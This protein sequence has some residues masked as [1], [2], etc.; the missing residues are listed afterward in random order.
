MTISEVANLLNI[1]Q[2]TVRFYER[3]GLINPA[4]REDSKYRDY[5]GEDVMKLK[6]IMLYRKL[7]FSI[8]DI[9]T[10]LSEDA[11]VQVM[12]M[13]RKQKL[14]DLK[15]QIMGSL[16]LCEKMIADSADADMEVDYYLSYVHEEEEKGQIFPEIVST[17]D[18]IADNMNMERYLGLPFVSWMLQHD[19]VRR[20]I[21]VV[22]ILILVVF[23]VVNIVRSIIEVAA[24]SGSVAKL[25]IWCIYGVAMVSVFLGL[26]RKNRT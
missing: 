25:I 11:D 15:E 16:A 1:D 19:T 12:L 7:D 22:A 10:L 18:L 26:T 21:V 14:E 3:K 20:I 23:H 17:I 24:G 2:S 5:S 8:E 13:E 9:Q 4:R 6:H